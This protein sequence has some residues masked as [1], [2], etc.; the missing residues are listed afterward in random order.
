M[1]REM[2][3]SGVAA[4]CCNDE[5]ACGTMAAVSIRQRGQSNG[6]EPMPMDKLKQGLL[7]NQPH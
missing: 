5:T 4:F 1:L 6:R 3:G 7:L 2:G